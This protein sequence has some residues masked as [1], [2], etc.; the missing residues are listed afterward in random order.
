MTTRAYREALLEGINAFIY[1]NN[2]VNKIL[3]PPTT[4]KQ[5]ITNQEGVITILEYD[6]RAYVFYENEEVVCITARGEAYPRIRKG[7]LSEL[8][9][10]YLLPLNVI[11]VYMRLIGFK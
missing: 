8:A 11:L 3:Q 10:R 5:L 9:P 2:E 6:R 4:A 1:S 7:T